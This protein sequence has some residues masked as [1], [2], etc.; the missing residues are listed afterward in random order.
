MSA[1]AAGMSDIYDFKFMPEFTGHD[2][3]PRL[4]GASDARGRELTPI[5]CM[6]TPSRPARLPRLLRVLEDAEL[7]ID[8]SLISP[9][10]GI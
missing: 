10:D 5:C 8:S 6:R 1:H 3:P 7:P 4:A 2:T 9:G